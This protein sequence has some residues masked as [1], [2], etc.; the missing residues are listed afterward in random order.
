MT[1]EEASTIVDKKSQETGYTILKWQAQTI[2]NL[3]SSMMVLFNFNDAVIHIY[4]KQME[5]IN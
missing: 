4:S 1:M 5:V 2:I 3:Y